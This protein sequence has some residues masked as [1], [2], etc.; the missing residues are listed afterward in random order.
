MS[1]DDLVVIRASALREMLR[2]VVDEALADFKQ[3]R[4]PRLLDRQQLAAAIGVGLDTVDRLRREGCPSMRVGDVPRFELGSVLD[5]LR[6]RTVD[7]WLSPAAAAKLTG[8]STAHLARLR[9]VGGG[10]AF[11]KLSRSKQGGVRY[12]RSDVD[13]WMLSAQ[14]ANTSQ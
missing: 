9:M 7:D 2:E 4:A 1:S 6:V 3:P 14:K 12:R 8:Y 5:W 10:P 11:S 13:A